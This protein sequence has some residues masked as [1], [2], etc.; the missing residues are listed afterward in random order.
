[1]DRWW[2]SPVHA[3]F[4]EGE[5]GPSNQWYYRVQ[6]AHFQ[7]AELDDGDLLE[8]R[9]TFG[10]WNRAPGPVTARWL[11]M[12]RPPVPCVPRHLSLC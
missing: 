7:V 1:M 11:A 8:E 10:R 5:R 4:D 2:V 12:G 9:W 6:A 3:T